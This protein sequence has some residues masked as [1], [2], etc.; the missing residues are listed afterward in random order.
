MAVEAHF[1]VQYSTRL[2]TCIMY[3]QMEVDEC[4]M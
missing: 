3:P 2:S 1:D 4:R